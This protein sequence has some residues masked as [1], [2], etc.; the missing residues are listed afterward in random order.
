MLCAP[1]SPPLN[2][3]SM[4]FIASRS[5]WG[6][7][8]VSNPLRGHNHSYLKPEQSPRSSAKVLVAIIKVH[9]RPSPVKITIISGRVWPVMPCRNEPIAVVGSACRFAGDAHSPSRLWEVLKSPVDHLQRIPPS[10]FQPDG[11]YHENGAYHGHTNVRHAYLLQDDLATFDAEFFGVKPIEASAMDPQQRFLLE[12]VYEGIES[13][14]FPMSNLRG[15]DTGVYVGVMF[16]DYSAMLL[17]DY[18]DLPTYFATGTGQSMLS[19]RISHFYDWHGP[20]VTVDTA[21]SSSLVA[22]HMAVQ[23]LRSDESRVALACGTNLVIGPEGFVVESKLNMLSPDGRSRM[24]DHKANGYA[25]GD[26]VAAV[27]C[28]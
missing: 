9:G 27:V 6:Q 11:F 5:D 4:S 23:A 10:R 17:R 19:N 25:R 15:S 28:E 18:Q 3:T 26:G 20:S 1:F 12:V 13:A 16:N 7:K 21:C 22:V 8:A 14:G 24:W 2:L